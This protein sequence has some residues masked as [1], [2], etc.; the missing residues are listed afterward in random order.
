MSSSEGKAEPCEPGTDHGMSDERWDW[1]AASA[2][3]GGTV[4]GVPVGGGFG[5]LLARALGFRESV[6]DYGPAFFIT[7][8]GACLVGLA[9]CYLALRLLR[10][11][12]A[13]PTVII[14]AVLLPGAAL[15]VEPMGKALAA[16]FD[17]TFGVLIPVGV[18]LYVCCPVLAPVVARLIAGLLP[19]GK[20]H[21]AVQDPA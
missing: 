11:S 20:S 1:A 6:A 8:T 7:V 5:I 12:R 15:S 9:G 4:A 13:L 14:L 10:D 18:V 3:S 21:P 16:T 17:W 2:A 19:A